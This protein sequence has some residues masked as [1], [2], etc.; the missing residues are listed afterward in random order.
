[1]K[2]YDRQYVFPKIL[3]KTYID[4]KSNTILFVASIEIITAKVPHLE[5]LQ[6]PKL[7]LLL[8]FFLFFYLLTNITVHKN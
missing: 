7:L 5:F 4:A 2:T 8:L 1:M 6:L 3:R